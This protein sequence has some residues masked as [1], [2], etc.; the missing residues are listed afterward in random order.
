[1]EDRVN[2]VASKK[3]VD[4]YEVI[5]LYLK[6]K[7]PA[8]TIHFKDILSRFEIIR[9]SSDIHVSRD[10]DDKIKTCTIDGKCI[11]FV[12]GNNNTPSVRNYEIIPVFRIG[13]PDSVVLSTEI[14]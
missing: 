2:V 3:I 10:P 9:V 14:E 13:T 7:Y 12:S 11:Y 1:M 6:Q 8:I 4:A 5:V